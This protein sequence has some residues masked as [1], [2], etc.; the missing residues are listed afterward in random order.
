VWQADNNLLYQPGGSGRIRH[1]NTVY[2]TST[3]PPANGNNNV[4][5]DP[6]FVDAVGGDFSLLDGSPAIDSG[7]ESDVYQTFYDLYGINISRDIENRV[8]PLDGDDSGSA[9]WDIGAYEFG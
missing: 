6:L 9:E 3:L 2:N 7:I 4:D 8:R 5:S 1:Y